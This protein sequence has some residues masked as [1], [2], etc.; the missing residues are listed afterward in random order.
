[1]A[2]KMFDKINDR[3]EQQ[4]VLPNDCTCVI[5]NCHYEKRNRS[6]E[7]LREYQLLKQES[8]KY[9]NFSLKN[10]EK[11]LDKNLRLNISKKDQIIQTDVVYDNHYQNGS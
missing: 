7:K 2:L 8:L 1:M 11:I 9:K 4:L 3:E 6:K 5:H 10:L